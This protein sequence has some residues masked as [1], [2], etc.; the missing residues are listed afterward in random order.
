M[1]PTW[2]LSAPNG[3]HVGHMNLAIRD[4]FR[5]I[6]VWWYGAITWTNAILVTTAPTGT[7][8]NEC[9]FK[10][11]N[12]YSNDILLK[13]AGFKQRTFC[14][15][16]TEISISLQQLLVIIEYNIMYMIIHSNANCLSQNATRQF[17]KYKEKCFVYI[18]MYIYLFIYSYIQTSVFYGDFCVDFGSLAFR[19]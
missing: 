19:K 16:L 17:D 11:F 14:P 12:L 15:E 5:W 3:P 10:Y 1:G 13:I 2:G 9:F 18:Y 7:R 4:C 6:V 8:R